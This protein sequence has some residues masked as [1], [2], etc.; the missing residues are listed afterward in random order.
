MFIKYLE[1]NFILRPW[2]LSD[3][4]SVSKHGTTKN[5]SN[6]MSDSFPDSVEKWKLFLEYAISKKSILYRAI[7]INGEAVGGIGI[8]PQSGIY[9]INAELGY[10]LGQDYWGQGIITNAI[11]EIVKLAFEKFTINRIYATPFE[12]NVA[13]HKVLEKCGFKLEARFEKIVNKNGE[14][15]DELVYAIRRE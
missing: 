15:L 12:N 4:E 3:L 7:E 14:F 9:R 5:I 8:S 6:F 1:M 13:S 11:T 2:E 10:W